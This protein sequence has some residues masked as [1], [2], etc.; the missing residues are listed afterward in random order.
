MS[1]KSPR[2]LDS[3]VHDICHD[4]GMDEAYEQ[5]RAIKAWPEVVGESIARVSKVRHCKDGVLY[6]RIS[7]PSWRNELHFQKRSVIDKLNKFIGKELV[8][9][10]V[11]Q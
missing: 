5:H 9:D 10:I 2:K 6:V 4:L 11:F 8:R 1:N 7:N 3:I